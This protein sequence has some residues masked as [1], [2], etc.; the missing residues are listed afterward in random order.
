MLELRGTEAATI[1]LSGT[2]PPTAATPLM[3]GS[4]LAPE[5]DAE[6][7]R[8]SLL[9][10][11]MQGLRL[12]GLPWPAF[13][14]GE[15]LWRIGVRHREQPSW[16]AVA[17][18]L[19]SAWIRWSGALLCRYPVRRAR[20]RF[21]AA[22]Q[23]Y[24]VEIN[25]KAGGLVVHATSSRREVP[26]EPPRPVLVYIASR[27]YR[28]PW[29]EEAA[30]Y[31]RVADIDTCDGAAIAATFRRPVRWHPRGLVH[32]GRVHRCGIASPA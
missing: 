25:G 15:A 6:G 5:Q 21:A 2:I 22:E 9:L 7:V 3:L 30:P 18:D 11:R 1:E 16:L 26:P 10:F 12:R 14:Y 19:D 23:A 4:G 29:Q 27:L 8:V 17:C 13:D 20:F 24:H 28:I 31:R 32:Q